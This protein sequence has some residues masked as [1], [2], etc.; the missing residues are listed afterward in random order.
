MLRP[1]PAKKAAKKAKNKAAPAAPIALACYLKAGDFTVD[2]EAGMLKGV[3]VITRGAAKGHGFD[4]DDVMLGQVAEAINGKPKGVRSHLGHPDGFGGNDGIEV[5]LGRFQGAKVEE[6]KVRAD[7]TFGPYAADV[8]G[9]GDVR[10]YLMHLVEEDPSE[11]A[12]SILFVPGE[13]EE[14]D[15]G[16]GHS[17][18]PAARLQELLAVD[19]VDDPAANPGGLLSG[20]QGPGDAVSPEKEDSLMDP[21]VREYL[22]SLGLKK[23]AS[24][25]DALKFQEGLTDAQKA[26][27]ARL[28]EGA[29]APTPAPAPEPAPAPD[30]VA[31]KADQAVKAALSRQ[32]KRRDAVAKLAREY[33]MPADEADRLAADPDVTAE[34]AATKVLEWLKKDRTPLR[35]H[36][37]EDLDRSTMG[38]AISDAIC[39]RAGI[40]LYEDEEPF[41]QH[42]MRE[43]KSRVAASTIEERVAAANGVAPRTLLKTRKP[44]ERALKM[45]S[46]PIRRMAAQ[47]LRAIGVPGLDG[48]DDVRIIGLAMRPHELR[49]GFGVNPRIAL[50]H[51]TSDFPLLLGDVLNK[52]MRARYVEYPKTWPIWVRPTTNVDFKDIKRIALSGVQDLVLQPEGAELKYGTMSESRETYYLATYSRGFKCTRQMLI[53]DDLDAFSR[54]PALHMDAAVRLEEDVVYAV[55]MNNAA[56]ADGVPLFNANPPGNNPTP[57]GHWNAINM[58]LNTVGLDFGRERMRVQ[59]GP[60][61]AAGVAGPVLNIEPAYLLVSARLEGN[62]KR[63]L[64]SEYLPAAQMGHT[65]NIWRGALIP[66]VQPRFDRSDAENWGLAADYNRIDTLEICFLEAEQTPV[67]SQETEFDTGDMKIAIR[68]TVAAKAIDYRGLLLS[69]GGESGESGS[70]A[71]SLPA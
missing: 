62:A 56:M 52:S 71:A 26:E 11:V 55:L 25:E 27:V 64:T 21:K 34:T 1:K 18:P 9:K 20:K 58:A 38:Q 23:E 43:V 44:H 33:G 12:L 66:V 37:G 65:A 46:L 35:I 15:D 61:P 54:L 3:S 47:Y 67:L 60:S 69:E 10:T 36:V 57:V 16:E 28:Q 8:P 53:N 68:H 50:A 51:S 2:A 14:R 42:Q 40:A 70:V 29:P 45:R 4:I 19:W 5:R 63:L 39:L 32:Q 48:M 59:P 22:E 41:S 31:Q 49:D 7:F 24:D 17:L 30:A 13:M 6:D